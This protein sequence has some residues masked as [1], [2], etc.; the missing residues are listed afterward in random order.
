MT[1]ILDV[2]QS[3][4]G[5][6]NGRERPCIDLQLI[7]TASKFNSPAVTL[8]L[9]GGQLRNE[10]ERRRAAPLEYNVGSTVPLRG[11]Q[12]VSDAAIR[13]QGQTLLR[14]R[15]P[16]DAAALATRS[17]PQCGAPPGLSSSGGSVC[18]VKTLRPCSGPTAMRLTLRGPVRRKSVPL[19]E[20]SSTSTNI[21][22]S[23]IVVN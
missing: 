5:T 16:G 3:S 20:G 18:S 1:A 12:L 19:L 8:T 15:W 10:V 4:S 22:G 9:Q 23:N 14:H 2:G 21:D 6:G 11:L 13:G 17:E 7:S